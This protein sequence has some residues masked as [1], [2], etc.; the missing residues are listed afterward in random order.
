M[1]NIKV[2]YI[3]N[4]I[5][6]QIHVFKINSFGNIELLQIVN[7]PGNGK[8]I[9]IHKTK[10]YLYLGIQSPPSIVTYT[11]ND[12]GL[13][14]Q[15]NIIKTNYP[16]YLS[17]NSKLDLL[18]CISYRE[19]SMNIHPI[20]NGIVHKKIQK[21]EN[22]TN[23]HSANIDK[24]NNFIWIPC[25]NINEIRIYKIN[26]LKFLPIKEH[27][28]IKIGKN[29][30]PRHITFNNNGK[31]AY[32]INELNGTISV[33]ST[34]TFNLIKTIKIYPKNI[35]ILLSWSA[36]IHITNKNNFIYCT[37]RSTNSI[38]CFRVSELG[39]NISLINY[40]HTEYQPHGF[41]IDKKSQ[42]LIVAGQIS[43]YISIYK[44]NSKTGELL[45]LSRH[46]VGMKPMWVSFL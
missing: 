2:F 42:F 22:L 45:H 30:G 18:Y 23:C 19:S 12:I 34:K 37:D 39:D 27:I 36:E 46:K 7:T 4:F 33:I 5:S 16:T 43:N 41:D 24:I 26:N 21:V 9:V 11:I 8:P 10:R 35:G 13:L 25:L 17:I 3:S 14:D 40:Y 1:D 32:V 29:F 44:I 15:N 20:Y 28:S 38:S 6:Q 31:Y